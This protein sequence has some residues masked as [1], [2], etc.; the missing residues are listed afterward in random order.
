MFV[1]NI[2]MSRFI[3]NYYTND[4]RHLQLAN[5]LSDNVKISLCFSNNPNINTFYVNNIQYDIETQLFET[6]LE[7]IKIQEY[8]LLLNIKNSPDSEVCIGHNVISFDNLLVYINKELISNI[9]ELIDKIQ[10]EVQVYESYNVILDYFYIYYYDELMRE[11]IIP[12]GDFFNFVEKYNVPKKYTTTT[13]NT[14]KRKK[15]S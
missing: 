6:I 15:H 9:R 3:F 11:Y 14:I 1:S 8:A 13:Y 4:E 10:F 5:F 7:H 2:H 12:Y